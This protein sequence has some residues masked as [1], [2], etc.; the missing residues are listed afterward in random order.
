[1]KRNLNTQVGSSNRAAKL[2]LCQKYWE[3]SYL[4]QLVLIKSISF[5]NIDFKKYLQIYMGNVKG[6]TKLISLRTYITQ[7]LSKKAQFLKS[8]SDKISWVT[9]PR[10][11]MDLNEYSDNAESGKKIGS[12]D[13][14]EFLEIPTGQYGQEN[15][16][17]ESP[18][19]LLVPLPAQSR[20][21]TNPNEIYYWLKVRPN[22]KREKKGN[23]T[24]LSNQDKDYFLRKY[25]LLP[26]P[27]E[28][29]ALPILTH[30][31]NLKSVLI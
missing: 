1:M 28:F 31:L 6:E 4:Y 30:Y 13:N 26:K 20:A 17:P 12:K 7:I 10:N 15:V 9:P 16:T 19:H 25:W 22:K 24:K 8:R 5:L 14:K 3:K 29:Y 18:L 21:Q 23:L 27:L 2:L 11:L